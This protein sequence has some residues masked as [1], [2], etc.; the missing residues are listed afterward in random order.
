VS[1][2]AQ[3]ALLASLYTEL[4]NDSAVMAIA[5]GVY[6][7][8]PQVARPEDNS[9]F[10]YVLIGDIRMDESDTD[11]E[12]GFNAQATIHTWSRQEGRDEV[13]RLQ[14]AIY[15]ALHRVDIVITGYNV[16]TCQQEYSDSFTDP[17]G[18]T[19]H[20]V[21]VFRVIFE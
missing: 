20:G 16:S 2:T 3:I 19:R 13:L 14:G 21:Q 4:S 5:T 9:R 1:S 18:L 6:D 8:V 7:H 11:T 10:P 12:T 17:D 15:T